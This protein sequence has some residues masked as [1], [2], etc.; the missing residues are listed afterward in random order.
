M[1]NIIQQ[2]Q[3]TLQENDQIES[4]NKQLIYQNQI[5]KTKEDELKGQVANIQSEYDTI[6]AKR[7]EIKNSLDDLEKQ[8]AQAAKKF[9]ESARQA[10]QVS[11]DQ[12]VENISTT[13]E[14]D[15]EQTKQV[16]LE[17]TQECVLE[18][19]K[20]IDS[21][22]QELTKIQTTLE[23]ERKNV[24]AAVEAAKRRQE[25]ENQQDFYRLVLTDEDISEIK[26]LREVLPYLRDKTPL[27][28]VIYKVY[29]EKPLTDMI[30]RVV[31]PGI[32]TGI[33]KITH[34]DSKKCY[35]G[36]AVNIAE[37]WKQHCK[38]GVGAEDWTRNKLY[39]AM[40]SLG[41]ENFSFE[42]I[43]E[44]ER[45]KLN[46]REKYWTEFF[47]AQDFGYSIRSG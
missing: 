33:Y 32:H 28:K 7:D 2:N 13:L 23:Q 1:K 40:Y 22:Q 11:F 30:G 9:Y 45:S 34:I 36:Q 14:Q 46:E 19:Q 12:E 38:R 29:Y 21:K 3:K 8:S 47:H 26:R 20:E 24:D 35:V 18:F 10:A 43:E 27:N 39:P 4:N 16:Y 6:S 5:L 17:T 42:I 41:V 37:R 31:G 25:I 44:C 15:R